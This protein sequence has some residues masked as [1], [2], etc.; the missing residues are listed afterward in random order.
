MGAGAAGFVVMAG[1]IW[2]ALLTAPVGLWSDT[3]RWRWGRRRP[4]LLAT[5]VPYAIITWL[6]FTICA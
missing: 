4:F 5:A 1:S 3:R 2:Q 6:M